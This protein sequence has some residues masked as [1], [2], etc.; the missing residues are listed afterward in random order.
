VER[1]GS[2]VAR[3]L[4]WGVYVTF[5]ADSEY[6]RRCFHEYGLVTDA[7][8]N[9]T[10]MYKPF[11]LIGLELGISIANAGL[12][13]E[14]TGAATG[15]RADAVAVAKRDLKAGEA[16]DGEG[17]YTVY[18]RLMPATDSL[19]CS[20]LPIGLAHDVR[21]VRDVASGAVVIWQHVAPIESEAARFRRTME[22]E[23]RTG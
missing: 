7:S 16:L 8:G 12:R 5:A 15:F 1:D 18:G 23:S 20:A 3:D 17:G 19:A 10:A 4:R 11:H 2:A 14:A 13:H 6:V 9:Y 22:E 21:L